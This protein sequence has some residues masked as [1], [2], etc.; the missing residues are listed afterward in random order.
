MNDALS[1]SIYNF[2]GRCYREI[3][4]EQNV[5]GCKLEPPQPPPRLHLRRACDQPGAR[6]PD[7]T[8]DNAQHS[9]FEL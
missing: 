7:A 2:I 1:R 8:H 9:S 5:E 4:T 6:C 3:K